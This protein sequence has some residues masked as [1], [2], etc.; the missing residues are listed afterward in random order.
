MELHSFSVVQRSTASNIVTPGG[1][2]ASSKLYLTAPQRCK[3][4]AP[5]ENLPQLELVASWGSNRPSNKDQVTLLT[6]MNLER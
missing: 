6:Q 3:G 2:T 4:P 1:G 5:D